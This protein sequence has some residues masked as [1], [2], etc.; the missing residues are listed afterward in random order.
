MFSTSNRRRNRVLPPLVLVGLVI[1]LLMIVR[2]SRLASRIEDNLAR[3]ST[4]GALAETSFLNC[5]RILSLQEPDL[6]TAPPV[7]SGPLSL[8]EQLGSAWDRQQLQQYSQQI[9]TAG[10]LNL[11]VYLYVT[12]AA[13][14][15]E[16]QRG[17]LLDLIS[18]TATPYSA[19]LALATYGGRNTVIGDGLEMAL[20]FYERLLAVVPDNQVGNLRQ[21]QLLLRAGD[22]AGARQYAE[23]AIRREE[24]Q[25][26]RFTILAYDLLVRSYLREGQCAE[27]AA[28]VRESR[29]ALEQGAGN[30][31]ANALALGAV[32]EWPTRFENANCIWPGS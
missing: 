26:L 10:E 18:E 31:A 2:G 28:V 6:T 3:T 32:E 4:L 23:R 21:A 12:C 5:D 22:G 11:P 16:A 13:E 29:A 19:E 9:R 8:L 7:P 17:L 30:Q 20:P 1:V 14:L 15:N 25:V 24:A 27:A